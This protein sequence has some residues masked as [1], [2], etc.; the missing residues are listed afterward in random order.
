MT[1]RQQRHHGRIRLEQERIDEYDP[2]SMGWEYTDIREVIKSHGQL[3]QIT[4]DC[5][6]TQQKESS[7]F[8]AAVRQATRHADACL[9]LYDPNNRASFEAL[10]QLHE[11]MIQLWSEEGQDIPKVVV[12][13]ATKKDLV[14]RARPAIRLEEVNAFAHSIGGSFTMGSALSGDGIDDM[15]DEIVRL[16]KSQRSSANKVKAGARARD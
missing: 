15:V 9:L 3:V 7:W 2:T 14:E 13:M 12:V 11:L 4:W 6:P 10:R 8:T 5:P 16:V 1:L